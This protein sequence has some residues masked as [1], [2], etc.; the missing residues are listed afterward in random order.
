MLTQTEI[1]RHLGLDP[2]AVKLNLF[3]AIY[4]LGKGKKIYCY[5][6]QHGRF[7]L[8]CSGERYYPSG[9][10]NLA[11]W[12]VETSLVVSDKQE[13]DWAKYAVD[14]LLFEI[15]KRFNTLRSP[16]RFEHTH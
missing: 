1:F 10:E 12:D 9:Q 11:E 15:T 5:F 2:F 16:L 8:T 14:N 3:Q 7:M 4:H 13:G 6:D